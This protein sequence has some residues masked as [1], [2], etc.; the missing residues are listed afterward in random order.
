[1]QPDRQARSGS[2]KELSQDQISQKVKNQ[3][4]WC[5]AL[6]VTWSRVAIVFQNKTQ[7]FWFWLHKILW[8]R[9]RHFEFSHT[10]PLPYVPSD[11]PWWH[12]LNTLQVIIR[13]P[14]RRFHGLYRPSTWCVWCGYST[15]AHLV[16]SQT[17]LR[18]LYVNAYSLHHF[19]RYWRCNPGNTLP[20]IGLTLYDLVGQALVRLWCP[21]KGWDTCV[22]S[23]LFHAHSLI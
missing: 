20:L 17:N 9:C 6:W 4:S 5:H 19:R 16:N 1:M 3:S 18:M 13:M 10:L 12:S 15:P 14:L 11:S 22:T 8:F 21:H 2:I 7:R 23:D